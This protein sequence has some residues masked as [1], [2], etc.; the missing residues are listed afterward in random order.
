L[1]ATYISSLIGC[2]CWLLAV[3]PADA[4]RGGAAGRRVIDSLITQL[5]SAT[6]VAKADTDKIALLCKISAVYSTLS[7]KEGIAYGSEA[8]DMG[9][10]LKWQPG[11]ALAHLYLGNNYL[12]TAQYELAMGHFAT[13]LGL[14]KAAKDTT[15]MAVLMGYMSLGYTYGKDYQQARVYAQQALALYTTTHD[16]NGMA[17]I[18]AAL[19]NIE[20]SSGAYDAAIAPY[21]EA[22]SLK[23]IRADKAG[24]A[25]VLTKLGIACYQCGAY[26]TAERYFLAGLKLCE[27]LNDKSGIALLTGQLGNVYNSTQALSKAM[28]H[29]LRAAKLHEALNEYR[30][31]ARVYGS[32]G[33]VY[34]TT[35]AY[36]QSLNYYVKA[37]EL[38]KNLESDDISDVAKT[39]LYIADLYSSTRHHTQAVNAAML[40]WSAAQR[41]G[42]KPIKAL[43]LSKLGAA[44]LSM[45]R[46]TLLP[47]VALK[48]L[49]EAYVGIT[50][51]AVT[52]IDQMEWAN[53]YLNEALALATTEHLDEIQQTCYEQLYQLH[54]HQQQYDLAARYYAQFV[55]MRALRSE[56]QN[57]VR[58]Q[59]TLATYQY[60]NKQ[61]ADSVQ[62][63]LA[64]EERQAEARQEQTY[65][66]VG[67]GGLLALLV[68]SGL[69]VRQRKLLQAEQAR[70]KALVLNLLPA[71]VAQKLATE[72]REPAEYYEQATVLLA[73]FS[74][75]GEAIAAMYPEALIAELN[76]CFLVFDEICTKCGL[77]PI[78]TQGDTYIAV[79]GVPQPS[80]YH[81]EKAVLAAKEMVAFIN[82]R[83]SNR[84]GSTFQVRV[85]L[86]SGS[87]A[88]G[89]VGGSKFSFDIWGETPTTAAILTK[90][91]IQGQIALS[92]ATFELVNYQTKCTYQGEIALKDGSQLAMYL[93]D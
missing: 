2:L 69:V 8:L 31:M 13:S 82:E 48:P 60:E 54:K 11:I 76:E 32:I 55:A 26:N 85:G 84:S 65:G 24:M 35:Q 92:E 50:D 70:S 15:K 17:G 57:E 77:E 41:V 33:S 43:A 47:T 72:G 4:Q 46:D 58:Q 44:H 1:R 90:H 67:A 19:G 27:Q 66:W 5:G 45:A 14:Y 49:G 59:H 87:V 12:Q 64:A 29:Y 89:I 86:H 88:A 16:T 30:D 78:K 51:V 36:E 42:N 52:R 23:E 53:V 93:V 79:S 3:L 9:E 34:A 74:D 71:S 18:Y 20:Y 38:L 83:P 91:A 61:F 73:N 25:K 62:Q 37:L 75:F 63:A 80:D 39:Y 56:K 68:F 6:F 40:A 21:R 10:Q 22:L 7:P 28:D 81:A